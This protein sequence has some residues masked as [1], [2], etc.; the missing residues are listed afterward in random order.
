MVRVAARL[1]RTPTWAIVFFVALIV[2]TVT[3]VP[4]APRYLFYFDS[5]NFALSLGQ[6]NTGLHQPQPPGYPLFV[7]LLRLLR[8]FAP[9]VELLLVLSGIVGGAIAAALL[10]ALGARMFSPRAGWIAAALFVFHPVNWVSGISN[11]VRVYLVVIAA[12][13]ALALWRMFDSLRPGVWLAVASLLLGLLSGFRPEAVAFLAP[14]ILYSGIRCR[15]TPKHFALAGLLG[16]LGILSWLTVTAAAVGGFDAYISICRDYLHRESRNTSFLYGARFSEA[17]RMFRQAL[18]WN[19]LGV[20]PWVWALPF[21]W[22]KL[23]GRRAQY[24]FLTVWF[25]PAFVFHAFVHVG[26]PDHTLITAGVL[27]LLG[28]AVLS[29]LSAP[30]AAAAATALACVISTALF[31]YPPRGAARAASY[32]MVQQVD[33]A[34]QSVFSAIAAALT[35]QT[36]IVVDGRS[37]VTWRHISYYF[38][39]HPVVLLRDGPAWLLQNRKSQPFPNDGRTIPLPAARRILWVLPTR[40]GAPDRIVTTTPPPAGAITRGGRTFTVRPSPLP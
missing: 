30:R 17:W 8:P 21:V 11:Q 40:P 29:R 35:P 6:F 5:V 36:V 9:S 39:H 34:T 28:A 32:P 27:C 14:L 15:C 12:S 31:F 22:R 33:E 1:I 3:R 4:L 23:A 2:L 10:Q 25:A 37:F 24:I 13:V 19:A 20:F 7:G 16:A 38:P 18:L 26:D